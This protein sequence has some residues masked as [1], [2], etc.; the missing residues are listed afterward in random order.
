MTSPALSKLTFFTFKLYLYGF[1]LLLLLLG[2]GTLLSHIIPLPAPVIGLL[3][4]ALLCAML[5]QVPK[6]LTLISQL[7][8]SNMALFF[9][10]LIVSITLY[11][12]QIQTHILAIGLS[13]LLSTLIAMAVTAKLADWLLEKSK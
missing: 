10:P 8:L 9:V 4:C 3:L 12:E 5:G 7:L 1:S 13:L 6:P 2:G 11:L